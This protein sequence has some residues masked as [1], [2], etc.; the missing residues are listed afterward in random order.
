MQLFFTFFCCCCS[1][2]ASLFCLRTK[3]FVYYNFQ[4][5]SFAMP[6]HEAT[7]W[8]NQQNQIQEKL[9][10]KQ[11]G[12]TYIY[13]DSHLI[14]EQLNQITFLLGLFAKAEPNQKFIA[15]KMLKY[16]GVLKV[17]S[18]NSYKY[19]F[20]L[21]EH[22]KKAHIDSTVNRRLVVVCFSLQSMCIC[23]CSFS[24]C[25]QLYTLRTVREK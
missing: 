18:H 1:S 7:K 24:S 3:L 14:R 8:V 16:V 10:V 22:R 20:K 23:V 5:S 11:N 25:I 17:G 15:K 21:T 13:I 12:W 19:D 9:T 6:N 4:L 2:L